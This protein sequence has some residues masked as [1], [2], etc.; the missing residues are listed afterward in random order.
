MAA[1]RMMVPLA[2]WGM[3]QRKRKGGEKEDHPFLSGPPK[4]GNL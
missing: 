1:D 4:K 3:E 2:K